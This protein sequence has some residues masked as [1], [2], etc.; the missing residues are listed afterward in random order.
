LIDKKLLRIWVT[1][2]QIFVI[3]NMGS[4]GSALEWKEVG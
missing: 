3:Q 4:M 2:D 1:Y